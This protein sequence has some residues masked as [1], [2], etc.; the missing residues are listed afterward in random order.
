LIELLIGGT[1]STSD[2]YMRQPFSRTLIDPLPIDDGDE[3][4]DGWRI[5][6]RQMRMLLETGS[7]SVLR[8]A[9]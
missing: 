7:R 8:P 2:G 1:F 5:T 4:D 9:S 6:F 3:T